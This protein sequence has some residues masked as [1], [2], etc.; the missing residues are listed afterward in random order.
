MQLAGLAIILMWT[1][2]LGPALAQQPDPRLAGPM[3]QALQAQV[4]FQQALMKVQ[5][6]D[7]EAQKAAQAALL[8][9]APDD[10]GQ[11]GGP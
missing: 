11:Y 4:A 8:A 2:S 10:P 7:A 1:L 6:E 3:I 5:T 9:K